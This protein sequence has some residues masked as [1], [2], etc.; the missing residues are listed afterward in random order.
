VVRVSVEDEP[1]HGP[2]RSLNPGQLCRMAAAKNRLPPVLVQTTVA[3][4]PSA[5]AWNADGSAGRSSL[6]RPSVTRS[7]RSHG[8]L[9]GGYGG[10]IRGMWG[11]VI[12]QSPG[13]LPAWFPVTARVVPP[14]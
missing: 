12:W 13:R 1:L 6:I 11:Y 10:A 14:L 7:R 2:N 3:I 4:K 8:G 5:M 9:C